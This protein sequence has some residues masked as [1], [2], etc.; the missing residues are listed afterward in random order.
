MTGVQTCA[1]PICASL[2]CE[3]KRLGVNKDDIAAVDLVIC[4]EG[5][6]WL[7]RDRLNMEEFKDDPVVADAVG[8]LQQMLDESPA[9][10]LITFASG[11]RW[12]YIDAQKYLQ[13]V[14]E[15][16]PFQAVT[17]FHC[18]TLTDDPEIRKAVDDMICD[19]YGEENPLS[20]AD[21]G[22]AGEGIRSD[23]REQTGL[24]QPEAK[25]S[26]TLD[27]YLA[28]IEPQYREYK[29]TM[30]QCIAG[31][32]EYAARLAA[33]DQAQNQEELLP[34]FRRLCIEMAEFW[35]LT[36][37][38]T[39]RGWQEMVEHFGGAFDSAVSAARA[40]GHAP[41][42]SEQTKQ[43]ILDGL[44]LYALEMRA[45]DEGLVDWAG[46]C[47]VLIEDLEE[48]WQLEATAVQQTEPQIGD[49]SL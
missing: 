19:L 36:E 14:Q 30:R 40:S 35:G 23:N 45:N 29:N 12:N 18:E 1:L 46:E 39:P 38:D 42:L 6:E 24:P 10:G 34:L 43:N 27:E 49:M 22:S 32:T 2:D 25:K 8:K 33:Q 44:E 28:A 3:D 26:Y 13:A 31:L 47:E 7:S 5:R 21:Y 16:L 41:E 9:V 11:E 15:E 4:W 48:Q 37:D 20:L 17:G